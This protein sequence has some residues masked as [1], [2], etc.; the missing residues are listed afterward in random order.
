MITDETCHIKYDDVH[1]D[2]HCDQCGQLFD[3]N[4]YATYRYVIDERHTDYDYKEF[5]KY[6][7]MRVNSVTNF[8]NDFRAV[9]AESFERDI[10]LNLI[11][12]NEDI[13]KGYK[14]H[15]T[16]DWD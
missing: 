2:Y 15:I 3:T 12:N 14:F 11:T 16:F 6:V 1:C 10:V 8:H 9:L 13:D 4:V 5:T 7:T